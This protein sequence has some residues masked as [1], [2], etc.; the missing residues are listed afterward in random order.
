MTGL[1]YAWIK[2]KRKRKNNAG[3]RLY[4]GVFL[5][6]LLHSPAAGDFCFVSGVSAQNTFTGRGLDTAVTSSDT[7]AY[8]RIRQ[9]MSNKKVTERIFS[10]LTRK[11]H[12]EPAA[13][14]Q[15]PSVDEQF[16]PYEGKIINDI[17][18]VV[19][20]PFGYD[21]KRSDSI[22]SVNRLGRAGNNTHA[23]TRK[24]VLRNSLLFKKG[25]KTDPLLIAETESFIRNLGYVNDVHIRIDSISGD[26][27]NITVAVQDNWS[28]G[29]YVR[30]V[31]T[32]VDVE[33][34]D[35]NLSGLGNNFGLRGILNTKLD[36]KFGGGLE[37]RYP[38]LMR[39]FIN[40]DAAYLDDIVSVNRNFSIE[41]PLQKNL[42]IFGQTE[43][44]I[45][46]INLSQAVWD[47]ISPTYSKDVS[48]SLG[49]AFSPTGND[50]T[51][52]VAARFS[53]RNPRYK[54]VD[55][56]DNPE[57]IQHIKNRMVLLQLSLFKQRYF[58]TRMVNSFGKTE[59]FAYGYNAS[60][61][62]G[63]SEWPQFDKRGCYASFRIAANKQGRTGSVYFE[64]SLS[65]FFDGGKPF[66][67]VLKLKLDMFSSLYR[68][69][70][71]NYRHFLNID[72][73]RR[74]NHIHGFRNYNLTLNE[75]T[76][77]K[78]RNAATLTAIE[79]LMFKT[80]GNVFSSLNIMGFRLLFYSFADFGWIADYN[81]TL[82]NR[83]NIYWGAG[84]GIRIR[85]DLLVF[86]TVELKIGYYPKV[87]QRGFN[88]F[89]NFGSSVPNVSPNFTPK[90]PEEIT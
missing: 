78:F 22:P 25:Q 76:S 3:N 1:L 66:E 43:V 57:I 65:S 73:S 8:N 42:H 88:N 70:N 87:R 15:N 47:S 7:A 36:R 86:R 28:V 75:L 84:L 54:N 11:P 37:Y 72:Y 48:A 33:V 53:D 19:L 79:K 64:G 30:N 56:P 40:I 9:A 60:A 77:M 46:E 67:G 39:T 63:Y 31:S 59:N 51:F 44:D 50:N 16:A 62:F 34:F 90:Y 23:N 80:E 21:V 14:N 35:R 18:I 71:Q 13:V 6:V 10:L 4:F 61:Q 81:K 55:R 38:N 68:I 12:I 49:Y 41:R 83:D 82:L 74:L 29:A 58:H 17:K 27:V 24:W 2:G 89:V 69:G 26:E 85:N 20:P 52:V 45:K 5:L 32:K